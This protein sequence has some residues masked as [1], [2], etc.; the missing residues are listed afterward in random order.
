MELGD[1]LLRICLVFFAELGFG[2][3]CF[4]IWSRE[5]FEKE[6]TPAKSIP[7][8]RKGANKGPIGRSEGP[9][10]DLRRW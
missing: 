8:L 5:V 2:Q 4:P 3:M 7:E 6:D 9:P 10:K 1:L